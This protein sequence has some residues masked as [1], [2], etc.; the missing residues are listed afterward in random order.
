MFALT[1]TELRRRAVQSQHSQRTTANGALSL[2]LPF[3]LP[4]CPGNLFG[5][6]TATAIPGVEEWRDGA[7]PRRPAP[8]RPG[9]RPSTATRSPIRPAGSPGVFPGPQALAAVDPGSLRF[10]AACRATWA[11]LREY[12][13]GTRTAFH[14]PLA[15]RGPSFHR[16]A[17]LALA[18]KLLEHEMLVSSRDRAATDAGEPLGGGSPREPFLF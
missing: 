14:L 10:P 13:A 3:R 6:P 8:T 7:S 2:R 12:F 16:K 5:H 9:W 17:W 11:A 15:L 4:L 18:A 1:P